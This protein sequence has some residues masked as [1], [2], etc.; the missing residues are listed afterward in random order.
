MLLYAIDERDRELV[1][2]E[3]LRCDDDQLEL[4][5]DAA[6]DSVGAEPEIDELGGPHVRVVLVQSVVQTL[7]QLLHVQQD[8]GPSQFHAQLYS[9]YVLANLRVSLV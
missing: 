2:R 7:V 1:I 4:V 9:V 8:A 6:L 3:I 5:V